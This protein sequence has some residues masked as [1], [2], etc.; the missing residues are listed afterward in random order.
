MKILQKFSEICVSSRNNKL[1]SS[2]L[3]DLS[4]CH[5][6]VWSCFFFFVQFLPPKQSSQVYKYSYSLPTT[7]EPDA[8]PWSAFAENMVDPSTAP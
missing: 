8:N 7:V 3:L 1:T 4:P 5:N 6:V 2:F